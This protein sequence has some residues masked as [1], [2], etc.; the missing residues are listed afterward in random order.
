[1]PLGFA[2]LSRGLIAAAV[3]CTPGSSSPT[4]RP[5]VP[6]FQ[7]T[8]SDLVGDWRWLLRTQEDGTTR[9]EDETW[10]L[11]PAADSPLRL[12]GRYV[13]SVEVRS[14]N[15]VPFQCNQRPWYRQRAVFDLEVELLPA[16]FEVR[17]TGY[18]AEPSPCDHGFRRVAHYTARLEPQ[19]LVLAWDGGSQTLHRIGGAS[20]ELDPDPWP[21]RPRVAGPWRWD[22]V[23]YDDDGNLRTEHEWWDITPRTETQLDLTYRRRVIVQNP[24][25]RVIP[26]AAAP[27][28]TFDDAYVLDGQREEEH[29]RLVERAT[30]P[31]DHPCLHA[32]PERSL[33]EA[34]AEQLGDF[35]VLE[36][37][38]KRRQV[39]Y[40]PD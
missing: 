9:I 2:W 30:E 12:V 40:R 5:A 18:R 13:R 15:R 8:P 6:A 28:W 31:G 38:G 24:E 29:W 37:R 16:G 39:L 3:A 22:G 11:R 32:T 35:L 33:D 14:D 27:T 1:M 26:C 4:T 19:R 20:G 36:W 34:T 7:P 17:E 25:G 23:S 21:A 10:Q